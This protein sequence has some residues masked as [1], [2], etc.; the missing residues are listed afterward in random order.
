M[1]H[2]VGFDEICPEYHIN[3]IQQ[4]CVFSLAGMNHE[5]ICIYLPKQ[6]ISNRPNSQTK[7][8][9]ELCLSKAQCNGFNFH[10]QTQSNLRG[11]RHER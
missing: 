9:N 6:H 10:D 7:Q 1:S 4:D 5:D 3:Q 11:R 8:K 2:K